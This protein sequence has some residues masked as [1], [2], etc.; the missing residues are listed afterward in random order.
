[1][2]TLE[3]LR[4]E[5]NKNIQ[6]ET[7]LASN[8]S[9]DIN[10]GF[11]RPLQEISTAWSDKDAY[12]AIGENVEQRRSRNQGAL[13][14]IGIGA[15][16]LAGK[17]LTK[18]AEGAG[19]IA[20][21]LGVD[22]N[23][24]NYG[25]GFPGWIAGAADNGLA[26]L[27]SDMESKLEDITPLY[28]SIEDKAANKVSVFNNLTD[29]DFWAGDAVDATAFLLSAYLTGGGV[30]ELKVGQRLTKGLSKTG[31]LKGSLNKVAQSTNHLTATA[32]QTASESMFEAKELRDNLREQIAKERFGSNFDFLTTEQQKQ[33]NTEV[34]P[35]AAKA[36]GLNMALLAPSNLME[37]GSLMKNSG[38]IVRET[39]GLTNKGLQT[40]LPSTDKLSSFQKFAN[41]KAGS[42]LGAQVKNILAEGLYEENAQL[43]V[44][45]LLKAN[46]DADLSSILTELPGK[47]F[48]NFET[49][50]GRKSMLLGSLIGGI[51]GTIGGVTD[52]NQNTKRQT[53]AINETN[54]SLGNMFATNDIYEKETYVED[55][56]G[57]PV[58]KTRYKLNE[59]GEPIINENKLKAVLKSKEEFEYLDDVATLAEEKGDDVLYGLAKNNSIN[60]WIKSH[61]ATGSE[62]LLEDKI[63]YLQRLSDQEYLN[64]GLNP[65]EKGSYIANLRNKI[66]QYK[67]LTKN[68]ENNLVSMDNSKKGSVNF[69]ARKNELYNIGTALNDIKDEKDRLSLEQA[70]INSNEQAQVLNAK[71]LAYIDLKVN[72][73]TEAENKYKEEFNKLANLNTGQKY[74]NNEY[75][76]SITKKVN[77]FDFEK[78]NLDSFNAFENSKLYK[79][80]LELKAKNIENDFFEQGV[81]E[82]I[83]TEEAADVAADLIADEVPVT[84]QTKD[85]LLGE[86][87]FDA[88]VQ[89]EISKY[90]QELNNAQYT[91]EA[92]E[93]LSE[94]AQSVLDSVNGDFEL[95]NELIAKTQ[96]A[97]EGVKNLPISEKTSTT[98]KSIK[99]KIL[100]MFT[101]TIKG[102]VF[103]AKSNEDYENIGEIEK[104]IK[105]LTNTIKVLE[106]KKDSDYQ[107]LI[108]TY[109][110]QL[111]ELN[112]LQ[113]VV[114]ERI[115]DKEKQ[116]ERIAEQNAELQKDS[117]NGNPELLQVVSDVTG[118]DLANLDNQLKDKSVWEKIGYLSNIISLVKTQIT[119]EQLQKIKNIQ[120]ALA[121][122]VEALV[123]TSQSGNLVNRVKKDYSKNPRFLFNDIVQIVIKYSADKGS[124]YY[125]YG[126]DFNFYNLYNKVIANEVELRLPQNTVT[127]IFNLHKQ[128]LGLENLIST[129]ESEYNPVTEIVTENAVGKEEKIVPSNQ[130]LI[131]IRDLVKFFLTK[132]DNKRFS[133]FAYL[134][135]FA[136]TGKTNIVLRF[137]TKVA[138]LGQDQIY[139][140]G[141]NENSSKAINNSIGS[142]TARSLENLKTDL[143]NN[144]LG[145]TKV[146]IIDEV[147]ALNK[148]EII[149]IN[150]LLVNYNKANNS[151][152]KIIGL[153][154][155]NQVTATGENPFLTAELTPGLENMTLITPLT[156]R[157]RSNVQAVVDAQDLFMDQKKDLTKEEIFLF[158]N[159]EGTLG[160]EGSLQNDS[161]EKALKQRDL[162]DGKT[163]AIIVHP[164]EV[165]MWKAKNLGVEVVSYIDVQGRTIDEVFISIPSAKF[166]DVSAFNQAMYTAASRATNFIHINGMKSKNVQDESVNKINDK[167]TKAIEESKK[168]FEENR[169][170][171]LK[172]ID[173]SIELKK[174]PVE[175][176]VEEVDEEETE[177]D[178]EEEK[179]GGGVVIP[180][181]K[182]I[183]EGGGIIWPAILNLKYPNKKSL[184]GTTEN[185]KDVPA[186]KPGEKVIYVPIENK[187]GY[188]AIGI[189][190]DRN[191]EYL[192]V[193]VLSQEELNNPP[194]DKI[195]LFESFKQALQGQ[196]TKFNIDNETGYL[197]VSNTS[198]LIT[199]ATGK[200]DNTSKLQYIYKQVSEPFNWQNILT[201]FRKGFFTT[202]EG[203]MSKLESSKIRIFT[204]TEIADLKSKGVVFPLVAGRPYVMIENPVQEGGVTAIPQFI[205]LERKSLN[206]KDH[207]FITQPI[208][209]F[210]A[211]YEEF[212]SLFPQLT[213]NELANLITSTN[214]YL[215]TIISELDTKYKT[216]FNLSND[217]LELRN[218]IN[219]LLYSEP[220]EQDL[221][222]RK[223]IK[224]KNITTPFTGK[225]KD[226]KAIE[227]NGT[228]TKIEGEDVTVKIDDE[229]VTVNIN[230]LQPV[231][232]RKPGP[233]QK[234]F[235]L[236]AQG[237]KTA[238]GHIIRLKYRSGSTVLSK[239]KS[240][241]PRTEDL[242]K[243]EAIDKIQSMTV[244][245]QQNLLARFEEMYGKTFDADNELDL[246]NIIKLSSVTM[247]YDEMLDIFK[248]D[249]AGNISNLR[250]PVQTETVLN[251]NSEAIKIAYNEN[252]IP[253]HYDN[254]FFEDKL[255]AI[256][257]TTASVTIDSETKPNI[258]T[259]ED[260]LNSEEPPEPE[261]LDLKF[262]LKTTE[263]KLGD[264]LSITSIFKYLKSI[265]KT[266]TPE[267][268]RFVSAAELMVLSGGKDTWGFFQDG[269]IYLEQDEF[270]KAYMNVARHELFHK[271]FDLMLTPNQR[272]LVYSRAIEEFNL[273]SDINVEA[274]EELLAEKYQE[275]R[276]E[277]KFS[278]FF[279]TLFNRIKRWLG[280]SVDIVPNINSF[281]ESIETG[282]FSEQVSFE[283]TKKSYNDILKD[284]DTIFNFKKAK[285]YIISKLKGLENQE[286]TEEFLSKYYTRTGIERLEKVYKFAVKRYE[287]LIEKSKIAEGLDEKEKVNLMFL[288][289]IVNKEVYNSLIAD[290]FEGIDLNKIN[291]QEIISSDWTDDIKDAEEVNQETKISQSVK[292]F[293]STIINKSSL[294][295][296]SP[297]FAYLT[298][299]E[300]MSNIDTSSET[301]FKNSLTKRFENFYIKNTN[302]NS[303]KNKIDELIKWAYLDSYKDINLN[304][305]SDFVTPNIFK[306]A[307]GKYLN[308][309]GNESNQNFFK[310]I[311]TSNP[312]ELKILNVLYLRA[313]A[314]NTL[315]E[316]YAQAG[317]LY[318]QNVMYGEYTGFGDDIKQALKN[319]TVEAEVAVERDNLADNLIQRAASLD[320]KFLK[321]LAKA[322]QIKK[323]EDRKTEAILLFREMFLFEPKNVEDSNVNDMLK[324]MSELYE[325]YKT[326]TGENAQE[327]FQ[328]RLL[329]DY[330]GILSKLAKE[331]LVSAE[332]EVRSPN[333]RR[334]DGKT[335]YK[336]TLSSFAIN[337]LQSLINN[338]TKPK[339]LKTEFYQKNIFI[340]GI[341]K[342]Y[343]Y[344]NFDGIVDENRSTDAVRYKSENEADWFR[345]NFNYFFVSYDNDN[346]KTKSTYLQQFV[347]ISNKPNI[348]AAEVDILNW[349]DLNKSI[350]SILKQQASRDSQ[351]VKVDNSLNVFDAIVKR[352]ENES[353]ESYANRIIETIKG[354]TNL[355]ELLNTEK[356]IDANKLK[357]LSEKFSSGNVNELANLFYANFFVNLHQL[358]QIVAGDEAFYKNSFD[359]VK[360]MSIAFATG[361]K[362]MVNDKFGLP[363]TYRS[364]V[365]KDIEGIL[366]KDF[367]K[368]KEI[369]G[370]KFDLTDA[371][372]FMTPKR[373][374][375]L[376]R[377]YGTAFNFGSIIKPVHF[378]IDDNGIPRA[379]KYSCVE[380]T[381]ELVAM[382]PTLAKLK[383]TMENE[384]YNIDEV[385]F[386]SA[387]KVGRPKNIQE[388]LK[389][390]S[391]ETVDEA[392]VLTL[393]N[394]GYR[395]QSN[396]EHDVD[397]ET[398][399][400]PTQLGYFFNFS[401]LNT[402]LAE[403]LFKA[404]EFLIN[405]GLSNILK[406]LGISSRLLEG[407]S[408]ELD[409]NKQRNN[410]RKRLIDNN[411]EER[412]QRQ[413]E[414]FNNPKL[415]INT[416][417][418]VK[419]AITTMSSMFKKATV[420]IQLPGAGLVLQ[421]A[422]GTTIFKDENGVEQIRPLRWRDEQGFAEVILPDFWQ[423]R[424]Q[425]GDSILTDTMVGFRIPS[426]ELHSAIPL[427]VVGFY[428]NNKNVVIAPPEI[429][430]FHG[431]D[432]D[433]DKLYVMRRE[434]LKDNVYKS[435]GDVIYTGNTPVG[436]VNNKFDEGMA[437]T[438]K[439]EIANVQQQINSLKNL[440]DADGV[441]NASAQLKALKKLQDVYYKNFI[442]DLFVQVTTDKVN[443]QLMMAPISMERFKGV[444]VDVEES[445][446]DLVARLKGFKEPK[447][448]FKDFT[449]NE[450]Y[451]K[452]LEDW[453]SKRDKVI[454]TS[455]NLYDVYDQM[456]MHKDNF[457]GT[458][459][460]GSFANMAKVVAYFFQSTSDNK[461][462]AL[463]ESYH[464]ELDGKT[465]EG[466][467]YY[468]NTKEVLVSYDS[469]GNPVYKKPSITETIDSL[470]NAAIDNVKEQ[471]LP[472]IGFTNNTGGAAVSMIAMGIPLNQ[473][474]LT[475]LQP[476]VN[477]LNR[478][479]SYSIGYS[480]ALS[481]L[482]LQYAK[483]LKAESFEALTEDQKKAFDEDLPKVTISEMEK[484]FGKE[485]S[486]MKLKEVKLQ[487]AILRDVLTKA[488]NAS[489]FISVGSKA[490]SVLKE[491]PIDFPE[492]ESVLEAFDKMWQE[493]EVQDPET[494][495]MVD[496]NQA[497]ETFPFT[498]VIPHKL[499]HIN[500]AFRT[501][502]TLKSKVEHLFYVHYKTLQNFSNSAFESYGL[503]RNKSTKV[504]QVTS[505][506]REQFLQY[507]M[508]GIKFNTPEGFDINLD[509]SKEPVYTD[510]RNKEYTGMDAWL[511]RFADTIRDMKKA[512]P[513]NKFLRKLTVGKRFKLNFNVGKNLVQEDFIDLQLA[514]NELKNE[515]G[516]TEFQ[517][518][519]VK[520][521]IL[522][523]GLSFGSNN[524]SLVLP[525]EIYIPFMEKYNS[526][527]SKYTADSELYN[528]MLNKVKDNFMV[529]YAVN[530][531]KEV[532]I[533]IDPKLTQEGPEKSILVSKE[534]PNM[535]DQPPIFVR[536]YSSLYTIV[537]ND[538]RYPDSYVYAR[539]GDF[540][541]LSGYQFN[542]ELVNKDYSLQQ[543]FNIN[544]PTVSVPN[545]RPKNSIFETKSN[546]SVG[547]KIRLVNYSDYT[548][549]DAIEYTIASKSEENGLN[550]YTLS[551]SQ[552][553]NEI[554]SDSQIIETSE[555][556][557]LIQQG[558]TPDAALHK[559]KNKC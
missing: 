269:I 441:K 95:L 323:L 396:P 42:V 208:F 75:K 454:Y 395:I 215:P 8:G 60:R 122:Q 451:E 193:G 158:S 466:Y 6:K 149:E 556:K 293:L 29:G 23:S 73:L 415:G 19:F 297:R 320:N 146:I 373:A 81:A 514:F 471:I 232:K 79:S 67:Q 115:S 236:I 403:K 173:D 476:A 308:R 516:F 551:D 416:P 341:N 305:P 488:N 164:S 334:T 200:V 74:F 86:L 30:A 235:N 92:P 435:N 257:P 229:Y 312:I 225:D 271:I 267:Q 134:K 2:P 406:E 436:Y 5:Y 50:E 111:E 483:L 220:T 282:Y 221:K 106:E 411:A 285:L 256:Q 153:G 445:T 303:I 359:V 166:T 3:E 278:S 421:S 478:Y 348:I 227:K 375:E 412:D 382:F 170:A 330:S 242:T 325:Y 316:L 169:V 39:E 62:D 204:N 444:G 151:D 324:N 222:L 280:M 407:E 426:T 418:L 525:S 554:L 233:A 337:S 31:L 369:V 456:L 465:Y 502:K 332:T 481:D 372:G 97:I 210:I 133:N 464:I 391:I 339:Y 254:L 219:N 381:D 130:Q 71:R 126:K 504:K 99:E 370:K 413:N 26:T 37:M 342:I 479:N 268:V 459:L 492:M 414:F 533:N 203:N 457:S 35:A 431:S 397:G 383:A 513:D 405:N 311:V 512:N 296:V 265:D 357:S 274:I 498:N 553:V 87:N 54:K 539:V 364:L 277:N 152:I 246:D 90:L 136:G 439:T 291:T 289:K 180:P 548:R 390:G 472:V 470:V 161:I 21:L 350:V 443:E 4:N 226:G 521:A 177:V 392:S 358:N 103:T 258:S 482:K 76:K 340:N 524:F 270:G 165:E 432:Y 140:T 202:T 495:K 368:F 55:V 306:S 195:E 240:L 217:V 84:Q 541:F 526:L 160:A 7:L 45:E 387:V 355:P 287:N 455:R 360:R 218:E 453:K 176:V 120:K 105:S 505:K 343:S 32:L 540:N 322:S 461:Y 484:A 25:G 94:Y 452:A 214:E 174:T 448:M 489:D 16:R 40:V 530:N 365:L 496:I 290:M 171:E 206:A 33:I 27:A 549:L 344:V 121:G 148:E 239:A 91:G 263:S 503:K 298:I 51:S 377:A 248:T 362:G 57:K 367:N 389:D 163:R 58:T 508:S 410:V 183:G 243:E 276:N 388:T 238:N 260:L 402:V 309:A 425:I 142:A 131:S 349:N 446:F 63:N 281:F 487:V 529:Q 557:E 264:K 72:E 145:K 46:R 417:F 128:V 96:N 253:T 223:G 361:Y 10:I 319:A 542:T 156:I 474:V 424:F 523:Q 43:A 15:T 22:N 135:G 93:P 507:F 272:K 150:D 520:Y 12:G 127:E 307:D 247:S 437:N 302:V 345:R 216:K 13:E 77:S 500:A 66:A 102:I 380:L 113:E 83:E 1:M 469:E 18:T 110:Q 491:F 184:F 49:E 85:I 347:T 294:K 261:D 336:F 231:V 527:M 234:A 450:L 262:L 531:A 331:H 442:V 346:I 447:P 273:P 159:P 109:K 205:E 519:L 98:N 141:H 286:S 534:N 14:T 104:A 61:F 493:G 211:K 328:D 157:Y 430:F 515:N 288:S 463:K 394:S 48:D 59:N 41:T 477:T 422:Y 460:T 155:P 88:E 409:Q 304:T 147:N 538:S 547:Q 518:N 144:N 420:Q 490:Y 517:Y 544:I 237:N 427:K 475:M 249:N 354:K 154:D 351:N 386:E 363:K 385:V 295:Q 299:L 34:A 511:R 509:T 259:Q 192:E 244:F 433:V 138:A 250:V 201:K 116:Q 65:A 198:S 212:K 181:Q 28:N 118:L 167:N 329:T 245:K 399:A 429:V 11:D 168:K 376:R 401:G 404:Q 378:E 321:R 438:I 428:P 327:D 52:Y 44:S 78:G 172:E 371:Q 300:T 275:W 82:R 400:F 314:R 552:G 56:D 419:K 462:P 499:P 310:R 398:V 486:D 333:Y 53:N 251:E 100:E 458:K 318:P 38:R 384:K 191:G 485:I 535:G 480:A 230:D 224:V 36:F 315:N 558:L 132:K 326:F 101:N 546:Y 468:E 301:V 536:S 112:K 338:W 434:T 117:I 528:I 284:F 119:P 187:Q 532:V 68:I 313:D 522:Q 162:N 197:N 408:L 543:A 449:T 185:G 266:L 20:G 473:V 213:T 423:D 440:K 467:D 356:N 47:M 175:P 537:E 17:T 510:A 550:K 194:A 178:L 89:D 228:V 80:G 69:L 107:D 199:L 292:Q 190:V 255:E 545:N 283:D 143:I 241:L 317:S 137:F 70:E 555:Y 125:K 209:D 366:G 179:V 196:V 124:A 64:M 501:L 379:I 139:A 252:Y 335:A 123:A 188:K 9:A 207:N 129:I 108:N 497:T 24:E 114:K 189:F 182:P 494:G 374:A 353:N 559:I 186:V 352:N 506:M 393:Q 279:T